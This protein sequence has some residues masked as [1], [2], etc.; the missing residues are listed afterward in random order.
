MYMYICI[1]VCQCAEEKV[2][3]IS[4]RKTTLALHK[5]I[6]IPCTVCTYIYLYI[7]VHMYSANVQK[8]RSRWSA[9]GKVVFSMHVYLQYTYKYTHIYICIPCMYIYI[10]A[11]Y[12]VYVYF[13]MYLPLYICPICRRCMARKVVVSR[14]ITW[15]C[16]RLSQFLFL[17]YM[18]LH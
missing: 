4:T 7:Y 1:F 14:Y 17:R 8:K 13:Q 9:T 16:C 10:H 5:Y 6:G 15:M 12:G 18:Y 2:Q 11:L 3:V